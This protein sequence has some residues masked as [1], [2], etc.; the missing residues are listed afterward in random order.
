M[1]DSPLSASSTYVYTVRAYDASGNQ[2]AES[3]AASV[4]TPGLPPPSSGLLAAYSFDEGSGATLL[5]RTTNG[6]N[7]TITGSPTWTTGK[8][9]LTIDFDGS[10]DAISLGSILPIQG[11][12]ALTLSAWVKR[13]GANELVV[14][15]KQTP[16]SSGDT[17]AI[18][19]WNDGL[20]YFG[21]SPSTGYAAGYTTL[22]DTA[23]HHVALVYDG[24]Q[25]G[26][27]NKLKGYIDGVQK[28]LTFTGTIPSLTTA[29]TNEFNVGKIGGA[30]TGGL[31]DDL[32]VYSRAQSEA[33]I[34][35]DMTTPVQ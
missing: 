8:N 23:W 14:F 9:G 28:T 16:G 22:N 2:S 10:N 29:N 4:T 30:Y 21:L 13:N 7:G 32:R 17:V 35:A 3:S 19:L 18:E 6:R 5:D 1:I 33:E 15:G 31:I 11:I 26:N 27:T 34:Q 25:T 20:I 24:T 12:P